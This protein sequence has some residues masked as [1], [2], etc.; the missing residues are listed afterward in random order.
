[1]PF[2]T[3][4][5]FAVVALAQVPLSVTLPLA[6]VHVTSLV[7]AD[8]LAN[9]HS[10]TTWSAVIFASLFVRKF[11]V[12]AEQATLVKYKACVVKACFTESTSD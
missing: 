12:V 10:A 11:P 5:R 8:G 2:L 6:V 3:R 7:I 4:T 1:M 9:V